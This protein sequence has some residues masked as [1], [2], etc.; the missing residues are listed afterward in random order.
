MLLLLE[1]TSLETEEIDIVD[2]GS[3][4]APELCRIVLVLPG[5]E[6]D[7]DIELPLPK[8]RERSLRDLHQQRM[9]TQL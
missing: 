1:P 6:F 4:A 3:R 5:A 7:I 9:L 8:E 2:R